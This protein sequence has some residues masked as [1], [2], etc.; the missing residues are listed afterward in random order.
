METI[1]NRD[2]GEAGGGGGRGEIRQY[3]LANLQMAC[4]R[5]SAG[6]QSWHPG[7]LLDFFANILASFVFVKTKPLARSHWTGLGVFN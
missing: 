2:R 1:D 6:N 3:V 7:A 4:R 5:K